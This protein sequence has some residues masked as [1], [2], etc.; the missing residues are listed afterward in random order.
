MPLTDEK[1]WTPFSYNNNIYLIYSFQPF[2]VL[3]MLPAV[4]TNTNTMLGNIPIQNKRTMETISLTASVENLWHWGDIRGGTPAYKIDTNRNLLF[5][6]SSIYKCDANN[7]NHGN[8]F[9][10]IGALTFSTQPPFQILAIS[11]EPL[12]THDYYSVGKKFKYSSSEIIYPIHYIINEKRNEI[13]LTVGKNDREGYITHIHI[14]Q[15]LASLKPV[16]Q[17]VLGLSNFTYIYNNNNNNNDNINNKENDNNYIGAI[18]N[19]FVYTCSQYFDKDYCMNLIYNKKS[20]HKHE[21][22]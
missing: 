4:N 3:Q 21:K 9:Y 7:N 12:V 2:R 19:S 8:G 16:E 14:N 1:N 13:L 5:F 17:V 18:P 15:L 11:P 20:H 10:F 6:H 22:I